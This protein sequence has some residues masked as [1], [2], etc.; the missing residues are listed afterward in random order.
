MVLGMGGEEGFI[1]Y[2]VIKRY[3]DINENIQ[4]ILCTYH[5]FLIFRTKN[6]SA[7]YKNDIS[8]YHNLSFLFFS[9]N[10]VFVTDFEKFRDFLVKSLEKMKEPEKS[11]V[12]MDNASYHSK[13]VMIYDIFHSLRPKYQFICIVA[14]RDTSEKMVKTSFEKMAW[15]KWT[16]QR[17]CVTTKEKIFKGWLLAANPT[18]HW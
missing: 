8:N 17:C 7:N 14:W 3:L 12:V 6:V 4:T 16:K 10:I 1:H 18:S 11:F 5:N 2:E 9:S 13:L 15:R